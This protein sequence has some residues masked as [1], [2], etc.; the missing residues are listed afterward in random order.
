MGTLTLLQ[1]QL[2]VAG[3]AVL[4]ALYVTRIGGDGRHYR[5]LAF[6]YCLALVAGAGV[7]EHALLSFAPGVSRR[8]VFLLG[9]ALASVTAGSYPRQLSAHPLS[10]N[11]QEQKLAGGVIHDGLSKPLCTVSAEELPILPVAFP[12][13]YGFRRGHAR[14]GYRFGR[15]GR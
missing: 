15:V 6:S 1:W 3:G 8:H 13:D 14:C 12:D 10:A 5:Y 2:L 4:V 11:V 7:I 9:L